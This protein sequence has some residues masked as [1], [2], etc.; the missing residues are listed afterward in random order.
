MQ[1]EQGSLQTEHE[2]LQATEIALQ[3]HR[4]RRVKYRQ[5]TEQMG[6]EAVRG[7]IT[8]SI[9]GHRKVLPVT[10]SV[11]FGLSSNL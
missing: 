1:E 5:N 9:A 11:Y 7:T 6:E 4:H 10:L 8:K 2:E 3:V